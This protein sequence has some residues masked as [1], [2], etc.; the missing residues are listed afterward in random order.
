MN[1]PSSTFGNIIRRAIPRTVRNWL[2]SPSRSAEWLLDS[3][4]F[5]LGQT[6]RLSVAPQL[7]L[8]CHPHFYKVVRQ[9]QID[10]P[11]QSEEF[12]NFISYCSQETFLFDIGAHFGV[13]SLA[14][15]HFGGTAIA[16]DP[17]PTATRMIHIEAALNHWQE[18]IRVLQTA[19]SDI[20]GEMGL[21]S[22]G[23]FSEGYYKVASGRLPTELT[24]T[25][26]ITI[27][28]MASMYGIP[29]HLKIDV[30][31]HEAAVLKGARNTLMTYRPMIFLEL[32]NEMVRTEGGDPNAPLALLDEVG[33]NTFNLSGGR[34]E[35]PSIL[36]PPIIRIIARP[37]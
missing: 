7:E 27:D 4:F 21:L 24:N 37:S 14:V 19:V 18:K 33:Y 15:A 30:E 36:T 22:S 13:F 32:H 17:S 1:Y 5:S 25:Q 11:Q 29:T 2:R 23:T 34:I 6:R 3:M 8:I 16:A 28:R 9:A 35:H 26:A 10:D 20:D 12:R 31:G